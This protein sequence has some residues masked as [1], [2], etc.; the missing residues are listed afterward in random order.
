MT[1]DH[2]PFEV[3]LSKLI[4]QWDEKIKSLKKS[5][6]RV[7]PQVSIEFDRQLDLLYA[8]LD[9]LKENLAELDQSGDRARDEIEAVIEK[10]L[11][12]LNDAFDSAVSK[13][14]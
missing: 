8:K 13:I 12:E 3:R 6:P 1:N 5:E 11:H 10:T 9:F 7:Q 2:L 14:G 4:K